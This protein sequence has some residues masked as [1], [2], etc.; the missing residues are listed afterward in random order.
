MLGIAPFSGLPFSSLPDIAEIVD[1]EAVILG[2]ADLSTLGGN[3]LLG[4]VNV[5]AIANLEA[6]GIDQ[7]GGK[8]SITARVEYNKLFPIEP[9]ASVWL[10]AP[11]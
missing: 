6:E 10:S 5:Y 1:G 2:T 3:K 7:N 9:T 4:T 8:S 11:S